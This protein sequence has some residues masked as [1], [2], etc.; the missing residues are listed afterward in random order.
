MTIWMFYLRQAD[1]FK[2]GDSR[3][4]SN[5]YILYGLTNQKSLARKFKETRNMKKFKEIKKDID[6]EEYELL[7]SE[8]RGAILE[9]RKLITSD[10]FSKTKE[11]S[12]TIPFLESMA[13]DDECNDSG[14][15][16]Y[17]I[18]S[19][20]PPLI[21]KEKIREA[22]R[23]SGYYEAYEFMTDKEI[24]HSGVRHQYSMCIDELQY[25][26]EVYGHLLKA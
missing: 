4:G 6:Q 14:L 16:Q 10:G 11:I 17:L 19:P 22:L 21:F 1:A 23:E 3:N 26:V 24:P 8:E 5:D 20:F 7:A 18:T 2:R 15:Y 25:F 12:I 13:I 9:E